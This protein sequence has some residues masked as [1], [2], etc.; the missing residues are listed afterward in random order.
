MIIIQKNHQVEIQITKT[1][2]FLTK[3]IDFFKRRSES[4]RRQIN[5]YAKKSVILNYVQKKN[6]KIRH[7]FLT[8][9][10]YVFEFIQKINL[11]IFS[12]FLE[13]HAVVSN[14][15]NVVSMIN[16]EKTFAKIYSRQLFERFRSFDAFRSSVI[17][18]AF[19]YENVFFEKSIETNETINFFEIKISEKRSTLTSNVSKH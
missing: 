12:Y 8:S 15:C 6:V 4:R 11:N 17:S 19:N 7:K 16:F 9:K 13:I 3:K 10:N 5:V 14:D 2:F 18:I 1:K